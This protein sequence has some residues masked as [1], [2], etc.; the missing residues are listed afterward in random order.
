MTAPTGTGLEQPA[1]SGSARDVGVIGY[2]LG[3]GLSFMARTHGLAAGSVTAIELVTADGELVRADASEHPDLFWALRGGG[4]NFGVVTAMELRLYETPEIYAGNLAWPWERSSEVLNAW[5]E[6]L[7]ELPDEMITTAKIVQTPPLPEIP[8]PIRGRQLVV[9]L[10]VFQGSEGAGAELL[11]PLRDLGPELDMVGMVPPNALGFVNMDPPE[12]VPYVS[13]HRQLRDGPG[14]VDSMLEAAGPG[15][16]SELIMAELRQLGGALGRPDPD[17]GALSALDADLA[18]FAVGLAPD[19]A[20]AA[21]S[22]EQA[23]RVTEAFARLDAGNAYLNF[24]EHE[25]DPARFYDED[26]YRRLREVKRRYAPANV[27][28]ANHEI[29]PTGDE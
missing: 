2:T 20:M 11:R 25:V 19:E 8:E 15:S 18:M 23:Q 27:I 13:G 9:V 28:H 26:T 6:L 1:L 14:L 17:G 24:T 10:A 4:G 29:P 12:P 16:G 3:G 21:A 22:A 7:P 5:H